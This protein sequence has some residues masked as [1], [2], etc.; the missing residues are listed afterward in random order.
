MQFSISFPVESFS[1]ER[2]SFPSYFMEQG[3][4]HGV[5]DDAVGTYS[6]AQREERPPIRPISMQTWTGSMTSN[7]QEKEFKRL[8]N[9]VSSVCIGHYSLFFFS[10][11][12]QACR[13]LFTF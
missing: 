1:K 12:S 9:E 4:V 7:S 10:I 6:G 11:L 8:E 2:A 13:T 5:M 3:E